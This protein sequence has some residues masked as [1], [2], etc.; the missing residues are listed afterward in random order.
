MWTLLLLV[1]TVRSFAH[2]SLGI[3]DR[4][5]STDLRHLMLYS[6]C[7][8]GSDCDKD[9]FR[10]KNGFCKTC[11]TIWP[12]F[13]VPPHLWLTSPG[14]TLVWFLK[15]WHPYMHET[16]F[17]PPVNMC[18]S[19]LQHHCSGTDFP[20][21]NSDL[22]SSPTVNDWPCTRFESVFVRFGLRSLLSSNNPT[23]Q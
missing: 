8:F 14:K 11:S 18:P 21:P 23:L 12:A 13:S 22:N 7:L 1:A 2:M 5:N 4:N 20:V 3:S 15:G 10:L 16:K 19:Q 9:F 6:K 17:H